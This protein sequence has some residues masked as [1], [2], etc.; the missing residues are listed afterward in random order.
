MPFADIRTAALW[1]AVANRLNTSTMRTVLNSTTAAPQIHLS[2]DNYPAQEGPQGAAWGRIV[3]VAAQTLWPSQR[4]VPG[5]RRQISFL[6]RVDYSAI[7]QLGYDVNVPLQAA[8]AEA[9]AQLQDW[10]PT[11]PVT[12]ATVAFPFYRDNPPQ[13]MPQWDEA[14]GLWYTSAEYH[15]EVSRSS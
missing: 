3:L 1:R 12:G 2:N 13:D 15:T 7:L 4:E 9:Y 5:Q 10:V 8:H 14:S 11:S 6:V